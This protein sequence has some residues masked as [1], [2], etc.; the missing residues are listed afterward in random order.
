MGPSPVNRGKLGT[1]RHLIVDGHGTPLGVVL[2][3]ANVNDNKMLEAVIDAI[4]EVR[5]GRRGRPRFRPKK[6][7]AD[8]GYDSRECRR[9]LSSRGIV[10]RIAR[11]GVE[12]SE[13]LGRH[14]WVVERTHSWMNTFRRLKTRYEKRADIHLAFVLIACSLV[15]LNQIHRFC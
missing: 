3:G 9:V 14:R 8:K 10:H 1:K 12:S 11:R 5:P 7:Y 6:V 4:P 2:S 13:K 15:C